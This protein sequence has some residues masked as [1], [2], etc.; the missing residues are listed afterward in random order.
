MVGF[1]NKIEFIDQKYQTNCTVR[2]DAYNGWFLSTI[3]YFV[4]FETDIQTIYFM[5]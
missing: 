3:N 5:S 4:L 1:V 2:Y